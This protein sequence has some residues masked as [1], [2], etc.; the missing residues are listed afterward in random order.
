MQNLPFIFKESQSSI[1]IIV[2]HNKCDH[3][4]LEEVANYI[5]STDKSII[6]IFADQMI[7]LPTVT[8]VLNTFAVK[9]THLLII[10]H[11]PKKYYELWLSHVQLSG[12]LRIIE[13]YQGVISEEYKNAF[14]QV[15][16][17]FARILPESLLVSP[18]SSSSEY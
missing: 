15:T 11:W 5:L 8:L 10:G 3:R 14:S 9:K 18:S 17:P 6:I 4:L 12:N 16:N 1:E 2:N 13:F 7:T